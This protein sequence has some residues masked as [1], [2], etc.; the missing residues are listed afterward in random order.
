MI[1]PSLTLRENRG[2]SCVKRLGMGGGGGGG[3]VG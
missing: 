2:F 3:R 1:I